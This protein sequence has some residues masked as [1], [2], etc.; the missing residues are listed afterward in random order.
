MVEQL[1][2]SEQELTKRIT[3]NEEEENL[4]MK[5]ESC[6]SFSSLTGALLQEASLE[7]L[8]FYS[9]FAL[10]FHLDSLGE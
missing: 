9:L 10:S 6:S 2:K 3:V 8:T 5:Q 1:R 4:E 7:D